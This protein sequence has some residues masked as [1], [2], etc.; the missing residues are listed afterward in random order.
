MAKRPKKEQF[1]LPLSGVVLGVIARALWLSARDDS[2]VLS[3][4]TAARYFSGE[5]VSDDARKEVVE[6]IAGASIKAG[7]FSVP[8]MPQVQQPLAA[9]VSNFV[10]WLAAQWDGLVGQI[11]SMGLTISSP[12][13]AAAAPLVYLRLAVIEIALRAGALLRLSGVD[14]PSEAPPKWASAGGQASL[15]RALLNQCR[16]RPKRD[17]LVQLLEVHPN[18]IDAWLDG[19][20]RPTDENIVVLAEEFASRIEG[21]TADALAERLRRHYA[22]HDLAGRLANAIGWNETEELGARLFRYT[23]IVHRLLSPAAPMPLDQAKL[24]MQGTRSDEAR[25]LVEQLWEEEPDRIWQTDL[26]A[27][28]EPWLPRLQSV[29]RDLSDRHVREAA[30]TIAAHPGM[31][32]E[33]VDA[34]EMAEMMAPTL[35]QI[36]MSMPMRRADAERLPYQVTLVPKDDAQKAAN[37]ITQARQCLDYSDYEGAI[38]H[39]RRAVFLAPQDANAHYTLGAS[40]NYAEQFDEALKECWIAAALRPKWEAPILEI[41][42]IYDKTQRFREACDLFAKHEPDLAPLSSTLLFEWGTAHLNLGESKQAAEKFERVFKT[43]PEHA[44]A[45]DYCAHCYFL[46]GDSVHGQQLA[47]KAQQLGQTRTYEAWKAGRYR[48]T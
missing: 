18:S 42:I 31:A 30:A 45:L 5:R 27:A 24:F 12:K 17:E 34:E 36:D 14:A 41:G 25:F 44:Q 11:R 46:L 7:M 20:K 29:A 32:R 9:S 33:A 43:A 22:L 40:L 10:L 6:A 47:K 38:S 35:A 3:G 8:S 23:R 16:E 19:K 39:A 2:E 21:T 4:K 48:E 26:R 28:C 1:E 15:L 13:R 37:R